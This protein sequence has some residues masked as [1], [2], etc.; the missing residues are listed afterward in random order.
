MVFCAAQLPSR[1]HCDLYDVRFSYED[2]FYSCLHEP[3]SR[4]FCLFP[5]PD[6]VSHSDVFDGL[7]PQVRHQNRRL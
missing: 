7:V 1:R 4:A 5:S 2:S 3:T 6:E